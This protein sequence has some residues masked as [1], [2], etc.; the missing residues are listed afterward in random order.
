M[1]NNIK[2]ISNGKPLLFLMLFALGTTC[3]EKQA[4]D[5]NNPIL[6]TV[7]DRTITAKD[8]QSR[9][10][11][12]V[13]PGNIR[14]NKAVLNNLIAEKLMAIEAGDTCALA[15][16][17]VFK[18]YIQGIQ[19]QNMREA[20]YEKVALNTIWIS[21]EDLKKSFNLSKRVYDLEFFTINN[22]SI[23][24][25]IETR[26]KAN[27]DEK[28]KIFDEISER[29]ETGIQTIIFHDPEHD[30]IHTA[31]FSEPLETGQVIGPVHLDKSQSIMM[32]IKEVK[33]Q[34]VIGPEEQAIRL[35]Q[36]EEKVREIRSR[37]AWKQYKKKLM[38]G[39]QI[40]FFRE[41]FDRIIAWYKAMTPDPDAVKNMSNPDS[42]ENPPAQFNIPAQ[43]DEILDQ[44]FL[45]VGN[46]QWT[47]RDFKQAIMSHPLVYDKKAVNT[48]N[49]EWHFQKAVA[50]LVVDHFLNQEAYKH[51]LDDH[52]RVKRRSEQWTDSY[53]ARYQLENHLKKKNLAELKKQDPSY[54]GPRILNEYLLELKH[55]YQ[56]HIQIDTEALDRLSLTNTQIYAYQPGMPYP[57]AVPSF[58]NLS[59][60]DTLI[61]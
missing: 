58:P 42:T 19:E 51:N 8:F 43:L 18:A 41:S 55:Q 20:L 50:D 47:V 48:N 35:K 39:K 4:A 46:E 17:P 6:A 30:S 49:F 13:R 44:P 27:P 25:E 32:R 59:S 7:C 11:L 15:R 31:L 34:P 28:E 33:I 2:D 38:S 37:A 36:V 45:S 24:E 5:P 3:S 53:L 9:A 21:P 29:W 22:P 61:F 40:R 10:E 16:N 12:T 14:T 57:A 1:R 60:A 52:E 23:T 56:D 54:K 26:L